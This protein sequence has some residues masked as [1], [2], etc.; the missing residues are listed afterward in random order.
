MGRMKDLVIEVMELQEDGYTVAQIADYS[1]L[2]E[3]VVIDILQHYGR[4]EPESML[5]Q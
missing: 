1:G 2:T 3:D 4:M 5:L